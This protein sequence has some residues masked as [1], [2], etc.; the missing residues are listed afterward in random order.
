MSW[1]PVYE[2]RSFAMMGVVI[3]LAMQ[4]RQPANCLAN[5]QG[6]RNFARVLSRE[7]V[8]DLRAED[9]P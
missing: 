6:N 3:I 2:N 4:S 5:H 1:S 7:Q 9:S 8:R